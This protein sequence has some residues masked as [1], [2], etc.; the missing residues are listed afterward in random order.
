MSSKPTV[1]VIIPVYRGEAYL[2]RL[3][4]LHPHA[5]ARRATSSGSSTP[6]PRPRSRHSHDRPAPF[7]STSTGRLRSRRHPIGGGATGDRRGARLSDPGCPPERTTPPSETLVESLLRDDRIGAAY[8]RQI[9]DE[10][11]RPG[12]GG[13]AALQLP[14]SIPDQDARTTGRA[15]AED[16]LHLQRLCRLPT[17]GP[18]GRSASSVDASSSARM[19]APA[20]RCSQAGWSIHYEADAVVHHTHHFSLGQEFRPLLRHRRRPPPHR[21]ILDRFGGSDGEGLRYLRVGFAHLRRHDSGSK[22]RSFILRGISAGW[23]ISSAGPWPFAT[24]VVS[25]SCR[26]FPDGG[27]GSTRIGG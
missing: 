6:I 7:I 16:A 26:R 5:E 11:A 27:T 15:R 1:S 17:I 13:Q 12:G 21:W 23:P 22:C 18:R 9:P 3:L 8:G 24:L 4:D 2:P 10:N 20:P 14:R 25:F 19:S